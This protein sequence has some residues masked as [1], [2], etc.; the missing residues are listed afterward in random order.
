MQVN[1]YAAV[2]GFH[3]QIKDLLENS[4]VVSVKPCELSAERGGFVVVYMH[5]FNDYHH[6]GVLPGFVSSYYDWLL[7]TVSILAEY[8][9]PYVVKAHL[10]F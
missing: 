8:Q 3:P 4:N 6:N 1:P 7:L 10:R 5:E 9:I 2:D